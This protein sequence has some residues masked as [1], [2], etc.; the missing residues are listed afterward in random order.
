[1][2]KSKTAERLEAQLVGRTIVAVD[3]LDAAE[4]LW[5]GDAPAIIVTLDDG[6]Q[7]IP[8]SDMEGNDAGWLAVMGPVGGEAAS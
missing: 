7:I 3:D 2:A 5:Y 8:Q 1:M 6:T 4:M